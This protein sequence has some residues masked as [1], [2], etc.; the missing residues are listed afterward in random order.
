MAWLTT[1]DAAQHTKCSTK[2]IERAAR[3]GNLRGIQRNG[4]RGHWRF[5]QSDLD[6]WVQGACNN[7]FEA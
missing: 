5:L 7:A 3:A 4:K 2:T 1:S 6:A